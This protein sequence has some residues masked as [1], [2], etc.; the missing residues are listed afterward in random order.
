M[1]RHI[2]GFVAFVSVFSAGVLLVREPPAAHAAAQTTA[3]RLPENPLITVRSS[4]SLAGNVNGP[5]VVRVPPWVEKPLGRYY[6]YFANHMGTF[7]R[8][9]YA[10]SIAGPWRIHEPGVLE[11]AHV[12]FLFDLRRAGNCGGRSDDSV[13]GGRRCSQRR[14]PRSGRPPRRRM[15]FESA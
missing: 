11:R 13:T 12:S 2:A 10:D 14:K 6:M 9:A 8:L 7:I 3:K 4:A 15:F 5:T 1:T